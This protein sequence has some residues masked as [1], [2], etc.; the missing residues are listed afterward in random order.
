MDDAECT[1][2]LQWALPRL[3]MRWPGYRKV[4]KQVCKRISARL[5]ELGLDEADAYR[6]YLAHNPSEWSMLD[7]FCPITI[8]RFYR[9]VDVFDH[10]DRAVLPRLV[11]NA[12]ERRSP[13]VRAWSIGCSCG[14]EPYT[15]S[16]I[17]D[18]SIAAHAPGVEFLIL[19]TEVNR[20]VL[21]RARNACYSKPCLQTLPGRWLELAFDRVDSHYCLRARH[22][23]RVTFMLQDIR[24]ALPEACFDLILCR[25][26]VFTYFDE[27]LQ[28]ALLPR[29]LSRLL[30]TGAFVIG[31]KE[32]PPSGFPLVAERPQLGIYRLP[33]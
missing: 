23:S 25:N 2:L 32:Q 13:L 10:L 5:R 28:R 33:S 21:D 7:S 4:R 6:L 20:E 15:V 17:W 29:I 24:Q 22:R 18:F 16:L 26:L 27:D 1:A 11:A 19:A 3:R 14:E 31:R 12:L 8:S 30:P 9:D